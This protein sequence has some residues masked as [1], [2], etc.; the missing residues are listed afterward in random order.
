MFRRH[1]QINIF[2]HSVLSNAEVE[3]ERSY[4]SPHEYAFMSCMGANL[5]SHLSESALEKGLQYFRGN[6]KF[7]CFLRMYQLDWTYSAHFV[8]TSFRN[9]MNINITYWEIQNWSNLATFDLTCKLKWPHQ[10]FVSLRSVVQPVWGPARWRWWVQ[11]MK[12]ARRK[13]FF[14]FLILTLSTLPSMQ[15]AGKEHLIYCP[16]PVLTSRSALIG[17]IFIVISLMV[18]LLLNRD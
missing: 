2:E 6:T 11:G 18:R 9:F 3:N 15:P 7:S 14:S 1:I 16:L 5:F 8:R 4:T 17:K 10:H 12:F 13:Q